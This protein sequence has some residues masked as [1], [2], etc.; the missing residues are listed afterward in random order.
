MKKTL[1]TLLVLASPYIITNNSFA[2]DDAQAVA[3]DFCKCSKPLFAD[4][5][6]AMEAIKTGN[7][8]ALKKLQEKFGD[9]AK[10]KEHSKEI[11]T[12]MQNSKEKYKHL[13][14]N[15]EFKEKVKEAIDKTCPRPKMPFG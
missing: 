10:V 8:A 15:E 3:N 2:A 12:C 9:E 7:M 1:L 4:L 6:Q 14:N 5:N 11:E 13:E